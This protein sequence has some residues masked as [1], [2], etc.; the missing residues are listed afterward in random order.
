M[1]RA[2][3]W[4]TEHSRVSLRKSLCAVACS[5]A[6]VEGGLLQLT[7]VVACSVNLLLEKAQVTYD[8]RI[9][10]PDQIAAAVDDMGYEGTVQAGLFIPSHP[11]SS[12][13]I[14]VEPIGYRVVSFACR[15]RGADPRRGLVGGDRHALRDLCQHDR[16]A[17][18]EDP[19]RTGGH[20][21]PGH[22][23]CYGHHRSGPV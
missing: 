21:Q 12:E 5:V 17:P 6:T 9:V 2:C 8:P 10:T 1:V 19:R 20:R 23:F 14:R 13:A 3:N 22:R 11:T 4:F 18:D 7:G 15:T 16:V